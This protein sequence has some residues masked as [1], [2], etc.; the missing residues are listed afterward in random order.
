MMNI[1]VDYMEKQGHSYMRMD[2]T[3]PV[4][5]RIPLIDKFNSGGQR[6]Q[7]VF[8]LCLFFFGGLDKS[9]FVFVLT[10]RVGGIGVNLTGADRV[11]IFDPDWY[12][13]VFVFSSLLLC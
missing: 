7:S 2:G 11:V 8:F 6:Q 1:L 12:I 9:V 3:T 4:Q 5:Q 13:S 10:T